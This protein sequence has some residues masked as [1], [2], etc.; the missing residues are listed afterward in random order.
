M[1]ETL[2]NCAVLIL[3]LA[4]GD[5]RRCKSATGELREDLKKRCVTTVIVSWFAPRKRCGRGG[6]L[7]IATGSTCVTQGPHLG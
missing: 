1:Y 4:R 2:N 5:F 3:V 6:F 7:V